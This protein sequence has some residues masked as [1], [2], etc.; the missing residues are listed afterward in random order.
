MTSPSSSPATCRRPL[1]HLGV[2]GG[3]HSLEHLRQ[4]HRLVWVL[5]VA[6][7]SSRQQHA[8]RCSFS[9]KQTMGF[10][11]QPVAS[12][13]AGS[14]AGHPGCY[15]RLRQC[16]SMDPSWNTSSP[17]SIWGWVMRMK[18]YSESSNLLWAIRG[19]ALCCPGLLGK[20]FFPSSPQGLS[21]LGSLKQRWSFPG[22]ASWLFLLP[23][24]H[25]RSL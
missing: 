7:S 13:P 3:S 14:L 15:P 16:M 24:S 8:S 10:H 17:G 19:D 21:F 18:T 5:V 12:C 22:R 6:P 20:D 11:H 2:P 25:G 23:I 9:D 4:G 1:E